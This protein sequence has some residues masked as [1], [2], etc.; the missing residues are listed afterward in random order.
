MHWKQQLDW[1]F[2]DLGET[3]IDEAPAISESVRQFVA[4][5]S[6][7]GYSFEAAQVKEALQEAYRQ[8]AD[9][10]MRN[11]MQQW[12]P[13]EEERQYIRSK[14]KYR[15]DMER[16]YPVAK[17]LLETLASTYR[18]GIIANQG[19]G[20]AERLERY[21]LSP[22]IDVCCAS[23][24][25]GAAKPDPRLFQLALE[26]AGCDPARSVMIGD[27]I[28]NDVVPAK[29]LGMRAIWIRQG[30]ARL[31]PLPEGMLAPDQ[32]FET[33][34]ELLPWFMQKSNDFL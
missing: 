11:I 12:L 8:L 21:G 19:P 3:L 31:Q 26:Q 6:E 25:A 13:T 24:E 22:Y 14:M 4:A 5:S 18:I 9:F 32:I 17:Q 15:K 16:P 34:D 1:I 2:F 27:R 33:I 30:Y 28:D 10:P 20:T 7:L 23:A 29:Q